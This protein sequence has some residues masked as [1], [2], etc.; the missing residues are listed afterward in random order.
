MLLT[1]RLDPVLSAGARPL[2]SC[3]YPCHVGGDNHFPK[4]FDDDFAVGLEEGN[5]AYFGRNVLRGLVDGIDDFVHA[6][7]DRWQRQRDSVG[8]VL[9]GSAMWIDDTELIDKIADLAAACVIV[10][11]Q[12]RGDRARRKQEQLHAVNDRT[13]GMPSSAFSELTGLAPT[14]DGRPAIVGPYDSMHFVVP[15]IR[16]L[17]YRAPSNRL[18]PILHAK[19]A[20]LGDLWWRKEEQ[21]MYDVDVLHFTPR[22]LWIASANFT[23]ASRASLEFGYWTEDR[24][25]V[26]GAERFLVRLMAS[27]EGLDPEA[28]AFSPDLAPFEFDDEAM[29]EALAELESGR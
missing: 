19:L 17:G 15:T 16:T 7:Q 21:E 4:Q 22:R 1:R 25:L 27:S 26:E 3:R 28:D 10:K 5:R 24:D 23:K 9:L 18:V 2:A 6:R 29:A 11:K 20:L 13:P 8:P 14:V 12:G